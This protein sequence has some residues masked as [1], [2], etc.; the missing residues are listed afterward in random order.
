MIAL[1]LDHRVELVVS[2]QQDLW[3]KK[4]NSAAAQLDIQITV[5]IVQREPIDCHNPAMSHIVGKQRG[6]QKP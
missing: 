2:V 4:K 1:E 5:D 3:K 6:K